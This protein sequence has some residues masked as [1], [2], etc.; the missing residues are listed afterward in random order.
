MRT[1]R[2]VENKGSVSVVVPLY[3]GKR[4]I[5]CILVM[6]QQNVKELKKEGIQWKVELIFVN[7]YPK[8]RIQEIREDYGFNCRILNNERNVGI[9]RSRV[10]G[11]RES[12][13]EYILMLDQDDEIT[14][15][16]LVSQISQIE[17]NPSAKLVVGNGYIQHNHLTRMIY[18]YAFMQRTVKDIKAY[19]YMDNRIE[20][21]GQCL[22]RRN[23][24][25]EF[26]MNHCLENNG[27][28]DYMLWLLMLSKLRPS[29]IALNSELIYTHVN[30]NKNLSLDSQLIYRSVHEVV[31][32]LRE[33]G[34]VN[35]HI[36]NI[37]DYRIHCSQGPKSTEKPGIFSKKIVEAFCFASKKLLQYRDGR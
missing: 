33:S 5:K 10:R 6:I 25:P 24:I 12:R 31:G 28:D 2:I 1:E 19:A 11:I 29:E 9:H 32:L 15:N 18:R 37:I 35:N 36:L 20:S 22:I 34:E 30:T 26:W 14:Q 4:Y 7:D 17:K 23:T 3:K 13:G 21:P 27:S 8:E 16:Y